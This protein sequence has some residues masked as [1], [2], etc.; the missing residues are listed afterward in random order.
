M[1][2]RFAKMKLYFIAAM[3][4]FANSVASDTSV[5][6]P[7]SKMKSFNK[8]DFS[9]SSDY[10]M[11]LIVGPAVLL[12]FG[13][14]LTFIFLC[15]S[16]CRS[17]KCLQCCC[18]CQ[19]PTSGKIKFYLIL[20]IR[21]VT[22]PFWKGHDWFFFFF[23]RPK[24]GARFGRRRRPNPGPPRSGGPGQSGGPG[25]EPPEF[26]ENTDCTTTI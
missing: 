16:V 10:F 23:S 17:C 9:T 22:H 2:S 3:L 26:F 14:I 15:W 25:V 18:D 12:G 11:T 24:G 13:V 19:Q 4:I 6:S 8:N 21:D 1:M 20:L 7:S 5:Y